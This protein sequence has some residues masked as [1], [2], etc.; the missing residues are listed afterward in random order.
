MV[1]DGERWDSNPRPPGPQAAEQARANGWICEAQDGLE[2]LAI[3]SRHGDSP[4][5]LGTVSR[6]A[7]ARDGARSA[8]DRTQ[9]AAAQ[10]GR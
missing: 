2:A 5:R 1:S 3:G 7:K 6:R 8:V 9:L 10:T 4:H